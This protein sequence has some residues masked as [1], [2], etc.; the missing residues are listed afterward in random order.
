MVVLLRTVPAAE[1]VV[2]AAAMMGLVL[3][4]TLILAPALVAGVGVEAGVGKAEWMGVLRRGAAR[5]PPTAGTARRSGAV[6]AAAVMKVPAGSGG[7]E[8]GD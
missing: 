1:A 5:S 4:W 8:G 2:M 6:T 7:G 3:M